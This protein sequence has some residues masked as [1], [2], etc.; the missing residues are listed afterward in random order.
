MKTTLAKLEKYFSNLNNKGYYLDNANHPIW[1]IINPVQLPHTFQYYGI[2]LG[3]LNLYENLNEKQYLNKAIEA[4]NALC[5]LQKT[6]GQYKF[7][8]FEFN[9]KKTFGTTL[10]HN[11]LPSI[12]LVHLAKETRNKKYYMVAKRNILWSFSRLWKGDC[13]SGCINQDMSAAEAIASLYLIERNPRYLEKAK[14]VANWCA[15]YQIKKGKLKGGFIRGLGEEEMVIPWYT[16]KTALSYYN[17]FLITQNKKYYEIAK[18]ATLF[19]KRHLTKKGLVHWYY[20]GKLRKDPYIV[21]PSGLVYY[22]FEIF[23]LSYKPDI[24]KFQL[25]NGGFPSSYKS[26]NE[27]DL[28]ST[29]GWS[30]FMFLYLSYIVT[31]KL[32]IVNVKAEKISLKKPRFFLKGKVR[33]FG[34]QNGFVDLIRD[35]YVHYTVRLKDGKFITPWIPG[36]YNLRIRSNTAKWKVLSVDG[37]SKNISVFVFDYLF[38]QLF[39]FLED[40][41]TYLMKNNFNNILF[42][43]LAKLRFAKKYLIKKIKRA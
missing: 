13:L 41:L 22:L 33:G 18:E 1:G 4:G 17:L 19:L 16:A 27:L 35:R 2:I 31:D 6:S 37:P 24:L 15:Q 30:Q 7:D 42:D 11:V 12:A 5:S 3:Y 34:K 28:Q 20:K 36:E 10:I 21:S 9:D 43:D 23:D 26:G 39:Y 29:G 32:P 8:L 14:K 38:F 40:I 25:A